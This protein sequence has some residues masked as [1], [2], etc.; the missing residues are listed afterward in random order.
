MFTVSVPRNSNIKMSL[1]RLAS[2]LSVQNCRL[3]QRLTKLDY[4]S[5]RM[6]DTVM[7]PAQPDREQSE[8]QSPVNETATATA[9]A[10]DPEECRQQL[11]T[12]YKELFEAGYDDLDQV[13]LLL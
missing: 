12:C 3:E 1:S 10:S 11:F 5:Q 4:L 9:P 13:L 7:A 8:T 2:G 6:K